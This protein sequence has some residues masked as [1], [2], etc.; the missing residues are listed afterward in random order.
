MTDAGLGILDGFRRPRW[1]PDVPALWRS[2]SSVQFGDDVVVERIS[3][4]HVT[5]L[6]GIDGGRT[7]GE[8]TTDLPIPE[9]DAH[10]LLAALIA[11]GGL[12]DAARMPDAAR[13]TSDERPTILRDF[14]A[15]LDTYREIPAALAAVANRTRTRIAVTGTG[16]LAAAV[17]AAMIDARLLIADELESA[18]L[19][20]LADSHHPDVPAHHGDGHPDRPHL[21]IGAAGAHAVVGPLVVPGMTS[22]LRC[23]HLHRRDADPAWPVLAVQ[24]AQAARDQPARP[25]DPLLLRAAAVHAL[26][27]VRAWVD[28]PEDAGRWGDA[29]LEIRLPAP[30]AL[31]IARPPHPLCGCRWPQD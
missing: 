29:A 27:L 21:H 8:I 1:R 6:T 7:S 16:D 22:C 23:A 10:R 13:T 25:T 3:P 19:I 30:T 24:W 2:K 9:A 12:V 14:D 15:A 4:E 5:W 26:L 20:V 28:T 17:T 31:P 11:A 18:D